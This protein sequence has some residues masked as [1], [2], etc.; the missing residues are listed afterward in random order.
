M[1]ND[2]LDK[3]MTV[4]VSWQGV[5]QIT[6]RENNGAMNAMKP[7]DRK[8]IKILTGTKFQW[9][10]MIQRQDSFLA[11]VVEHTFENGAY[12]EKIEFFSRDN[13]R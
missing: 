2:Y 1:I 7:G 12:T 6:G 10:A 4:P 5:W 11:L 3:N 9:I 8:T 13:S